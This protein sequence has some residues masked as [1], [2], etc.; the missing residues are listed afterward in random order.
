[1]KSPLALTM[2]LLVLAFPAA[3]PV[4]AAEDGG[5]D[6]GAERP[7]FVVIFC[8]DLGYGDLGAFG[9]PTIRTPN[10]DRMAREGQRWTQFYS[11]AAV[12]TPS[13]AALLTGRYAQRSGTAGGVFFPDSAG[14]LPDSET[15]IAEA[16]KRADY[17]TAAIGKWHLGHLP[18]HLP[19]TQGFDMYYG[20]PY[21]NDMAKR[22]GPGYRGKARE[23]ADYEAEYEYWNVPLMRGE[24]VIERPVDQNTI[25]KR[26]TEEAVRFIREHK[27]GPFF[28]YLAHSM[29]HIPLFASE[30]FEGVSRRGQYGDVMAEIDWS[31]GRVL[32]TLRE[33]G[34]AENTLVVFTSD[35]GPWLIFDT[36][37]GSAGL[38]RGG[39]NTTWEG[40]MREP[41]I[42][43]W[44]GH[45]ERGPVM[46]LGSTLDL[47]PTFC[48]LAGVEPPGDRTLDGYDLTPALLGEGESPRDEMFFHHGGE[49]RAVRKGPYKAHFITTDKGYGRG[50][51][52]QRHDPPLLYHLGHDP[53]EQYNIAANHPGVIAEL[54]EL[55]GEHMETFEPVENQLSKK[56]EDE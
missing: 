24:E 27:E 30:G 10:L 56:V 13:R 36:H 44:P 39:K 46:R 9:H 26:Y 6:S 55:A 37:G 33:E 21:S 4:A 15:T 12:C 11:A 41:T 2:A 34:L 50:R 42:F 32:D 38:L 54:R 25:T 53:S 3:R 51:N 14:G 49:L 22:S 23:D 17:A 52:K 48:S 19:M 40:G 1:M 18:E 7:N 43:W 31:V 35:N 16:L 47:L 29:M 45:L 28:V 5:G 8:D 20:I